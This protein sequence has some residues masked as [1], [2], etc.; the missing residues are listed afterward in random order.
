MLMDKTPTTRC[1]FR[2]TAVTVGVPGSET[3]VTLDAVYP[4]P[5]LDGYAHDE[6]DAF[7][8]ATPFAKLEMQI[9]NPYGAELFQAGEFIYG[10]FTPAPNPYKQGGDETTGS[11]V[12]A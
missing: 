2:V 1:K 6:D 9:Q 10:D 12:V 3:R 8:N 5:E 7:F 11:P 4:N